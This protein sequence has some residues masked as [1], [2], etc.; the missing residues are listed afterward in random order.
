MLV[1]YDAESGKKGA[2]EANQDTGKGQAAAPKIESKAVAPLEAICLT[3]F[4][5]KEL[6]S[7]FR[8]VDCGLEIVCNH[9]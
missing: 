5:R 8:S 4:K 6:A 9:L 2:K 7:H 3:T 1:A